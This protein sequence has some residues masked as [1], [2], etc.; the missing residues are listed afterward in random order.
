MLI[1]RE[2]YLKIQKVLPVV[3]V[4]VLIMF[5]GKCLLLLRDNEP[6]KGMYWFPGGRIYKNET[7]I[8]AALRKAKE[9]TNLSCMFNRIVSVEESI[10]ELSDTMLNSVHTI[11][12]CC[13]MDV[14]EIG[15]LKIDLLHLNYKWVD[16]IDKNFHSA[17]KNPLSEIGFT[18][19]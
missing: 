18:N 6:A 19:G 13:L 12:V 16:K 14:C 15:K 9:E 1:P 11:N 10:F 3:C 7:I 17:I 2:D 8:N 5:G 4:D